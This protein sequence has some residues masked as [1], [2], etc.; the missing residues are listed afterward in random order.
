LGRQARHSLLKSE[1]SFEQRH[2]Q[3]AG[4]RRRTG[5]DF[6][7]KGGVSGRSLNIWARIK[8]PGAK[9]SKAK[10]SKAKQSR[11]QKKNSMVGSG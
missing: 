1:Q 7:S 6:I 5:A 2:T 9:Q 3:G 11:A 10:Q 4:I 8:Y